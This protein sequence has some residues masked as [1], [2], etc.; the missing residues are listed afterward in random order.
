MKTGR[1]R[2]P[3]QPPLGKTGEAC[4]TDSAV[5]QGGKDTAAPFAIPVESCSPRSQPTASYRTTLE[6]ALSTLHHSTWERSLHSALSLLILISI[7]RL[8]CARYWGGVKEISTSP[9][10]SL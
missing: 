4:P 7:Y 3:H 9:S 1:K 6:A 10:T 8:P 2:P 5:H